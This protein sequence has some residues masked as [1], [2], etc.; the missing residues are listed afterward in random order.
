[1]ATDMAA[2]TNPG[3][4]KVNRKD[5]EKMLDNSNYLGRHGENIENTSRKTC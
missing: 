1:M 3:P 2:I 4:F 5:P